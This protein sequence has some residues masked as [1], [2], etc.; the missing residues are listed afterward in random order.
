VSGLRV[1]VAGGG[2]GGLCL[3]QGLLKAGVDVTVYER[4]AQLAGRRQGYRL[5]VDARA[6][7]ALEQCLPPGSLAVFQATCSEASTRL[8]VVSER[9]RV[10]NEQGRTGDADPYAPAT[11]STS[12]NRQTLREVLAAGLEGRLVFGCELTGYELADSQ[13][14]GSQLAG[15]GDGRGGVRLHFAD[16]RQA[17][18]DLLVG[19]DGVGSAVRR[20]YLPAAAPADTGKR[21]VYGTIPLGPGEADRLPSALRDGFT[22]VIGGQVGMATGVVRFRQ[23]PEQAAP[24]LSPAGDYLM[25]AVAGDARRFGVA[26]ERL[27]AMA[28]AELHA[29]TAGMIRSWHPDLRALH[30]RAAVDETFLVR[31]RTSPPVPPWPPSRVTVLGDAIHA[32]SPARG[33]GANTALQDAALLCRTLTGAAGN[34]ARTGLAGSGTARAGSGAVRNGGDLI[35]AVGVYERQM[36][37]YGYAAV[38]ASQAAEAETGARHNRLMFWLYRRM[39]GARA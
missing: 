19:A 30:A 36:R 13:P 2:L 11:L 7:L 38:A 24:W 21:C 33:S 22:A 16:G 31:I 9:L 29:L 3:A 12:V 14:A 18:A 37:D 4:D 10:L 32:M 20:Q 28:P 8:T 23:R 6:G 1:A 35:A 25:W 39:T 26:D 5:H 17:E 34:G 15:Q 27:T